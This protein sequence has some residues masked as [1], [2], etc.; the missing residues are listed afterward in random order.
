MTDAPAAGSD[1]S[2]GPPDGFQPRGGIVGFFIM[3]LGMFM[4]ILDIQIV[5]SS[6]PEIQAGVSASVDE[7][8]W[9]QTAYLVAEVVMIP[10]SGWLAQ[11]MSSRWLFAA[12]AAGFTLTSITCAFAWDIN[13]LIVFRAAQGFIG[14]AMIPTVFAAN[15]KLLPPN[16]R[17][18]GT[19]VLGLTAT[20]A[21]ATGP[22]IGGWITEH[23]SW[24]WLFLANV[25]PGLFITVAVPLMVNI[26]R[27][28]PGLLRHIDL[29]GIVL[30]A[31]F[32]GSLEF[33]LDEGPREDWF[34]NRTILI[35]AIVSA[36]SGLLL[37]WREMVAEHPVIDFRVFANRNFAVG[38]I[39][40]FIVGICLYGQ[41]FILPQVLSQIRG[42]NSLQIGHVMFVT[43]AAMFCTAPIAGRVSNTLDPRGPLLIGFALVATG[44]WLN[45]HMTAEVGFDQLLAPQIVRGVGLMLCIVPI[46]ATA[47]GTMDQHL[48]S[49]G[50][51]L[52]NVF[53]NMGGAV[54]L[55]LINTQWD[56][57]YDLHYWR[58][59]ESMPAG[60]PE[61]QAFLQGV[62]D[63]METFGPQI[64]HPDLASYAVATRTVA[65]Q[66][67]V[68][69]WNDVFFMLSMAFIVFAPLVLLQSKPVGGGDGGGGH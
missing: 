50:S 17:M 16:K 1:P 56:S 7:V 65:Q 54:G 55:S 28:K 12:S 32:L 43:G 15:Y 10:L 2:Q 68:M 61:T 34:E 11:V 47:L 51:G 45:A 20:V 48:V 4:A 44:L 49:I 41:T 64:G 62:Q 60:R 6:L 39:L 33:V 31:G 22:T 26:D 5:A 57:R 53:R 21:P 24:H 66:A 67:N 63:R 18:L 36:V 37:I 52:F 8:T 13:S 35:F 42:Y 29:I 58:I 46:T 38:C 27:A 69:A 40:V 19:V 59:A 23:F 3:V 25:L 9:V 30:V 14:G